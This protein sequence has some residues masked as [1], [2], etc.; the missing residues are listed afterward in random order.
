MNYR[1]G[2][3]LIEMLLVLA[4]IGIVSAIAIP[5]LLGQRERARQRAT[6]A[7][8]QSVLAEAT[9]T[10]RTQTDA[11]ATTVM[12]YVRAI[13]NFAYPACKN[14]YNPTLTALT[15]SGAATAIGE[16]GMVATT[17]TDPNGTELNVIAI[18]YKHNDSGGTKVMAYVPLD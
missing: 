13:P 5:S 17:Q 1:S 10:A 2:F 18:S 15:S 14:P 12:A 8:A 7:T 6:E 11:T 16:V 9:A 4:I 3:T